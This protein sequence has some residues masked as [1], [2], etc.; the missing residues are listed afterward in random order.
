MLKELQQ[1]RGDSGSDANEEVDDDEEDVGR[2]GHLKPE[3][4]RVHDGGDGPAGEASNRSAHEHGRTVEPTGELWDCSSPSP[5]LPGVSHPRVHSPLATGATEL[6][7]RGTERSGLD[8]ACLATVQ[9]GHQ[10]DPLVHPD[11]TPPLLTPSDQHT[12]TAERVRGRLGSWWER[13]M[14]GG[15]TRKG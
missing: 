13:Y 2:A 7:D 15:Q 4:G 9:M 8:P 1:E 6:K 14:P 3:G 5:I 12:H 11:F 10:K